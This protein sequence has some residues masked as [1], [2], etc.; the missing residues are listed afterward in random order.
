MGYKTPLDYNSHAQEDI[1]WQMRDKTTTNGPPAGGAR[2]ERRD[3]NVRAGLAELDLWLHDALQSGLAAIR[4]E[5][6]REIAARMVDAQAPGIARR[7]IAMSQLP[8]D[9]PDRLLEH[10]ARLHLLIRGYTRLDALP[11]GTQA[12]I[13]A[14]IGF[15]EKQDDLRNQP[16]S[17]DRWLVMGRKVD[18][19]ENSLQT[20]RSWL[21]GR[22]TGR[23]ALILQFAFAQRPPDEGILPGAVL[24][25]EIVFFSS[26]Y[27]LR[28]LIKMQYGEPFPTRIFAAGY[29]SVRDAV[30]AYADALALNPWIERF[31]MSLSAVYPLHDGE[32]MILADAS[33]DALPM[34]SVDWRLVALSGGRPI[35]VFGEYVEGMFSVFSV[36]A[37]GRFVTL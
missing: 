9:E 16:G 11:P 23:T 32:K 22:Q 17:R 13:R 8:P 34:R 20:V 37:D 35:A 1:F 25:A 19:D 27:P 14:Q 36:W 30:R 21:I 18:I 29:A 4:P 6:W 33:G 26:A 15:T 2:A 28:G 7:L 12:D 24:D 10:I 31:P 3:A 5:T